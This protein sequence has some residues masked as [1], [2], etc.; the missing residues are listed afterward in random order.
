MD[1]ERWRNIEKLYESVVERS[2]AERARLLAEA[3]PDVRAEVEAMLAQPSGGALLDQHAPDLVSESSVIPLSIGTRLGHYQIGAMLGRGGMGEVYRARDTK[4][5]R[6][7]AIKVLPENFAQDPDRLARFTRES[8]VLAA[9]NHPNIATI[10]GVEEATFVMELVQGESLRTVLERGPL[11]LEIAL[12][13]A[14]QIC[15]A[16]EAAHDKGIVHRDLKPANIMVTGLIKVLDFGLATI[17]HDPTTTPGDRANSPTLTKAGVILGTAAYMSPEQAA[18]K[19]VDKRAD[20]WSFGVVLWEMLTGH[21]LFHGETTSDILAGVLRAPIDLNQLPRDTPASIRALLPRC[22]D[23]NARNRL[24]DIGEA[25]LAIQNAGK[26]P[27]AVSLS[28]IRRM[29]IVWPAIAGVLLLSIALLLVREWRS[30][31]ESVIV[32][33]ARATLEL[34]PA[35]H[36]TNDHQGRPHH[37]AMAFSPD[38]KVLVFA[39]TAG[40]TT[41]LYKRPLDQ[42]E[43]VPI[44]G[45]E[46]GDGPFFSPDGK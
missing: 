8:Q 6:D 15:D 28:P 41:Q 36:L 23:R 21:Q 33:P 4:L 26:E 44:P 42:A 34:T 12:Q 27:P 9:L 10:Y 22:L 40:T 18:G 37:T 29:P 1:P 30:S 3:D 16:L 31:A 14:A 2:P 39:G 24:R 11:L 38:G 35:E 43:A 25:R 32:T 7:V 20:I 13:Y 19:A 46:G 45:T 17:S 5:G